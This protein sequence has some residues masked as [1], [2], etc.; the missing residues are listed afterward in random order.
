MNIVV[1]MIKAQADELQSR[2]L[3]LVQDLPDLWQQKHGEKFLLSSLTSSSRHGSGSGSGTG[4]HTSQGVPRTPIH[5]LA[6]ASQQEVIDHATTT[7]ANASTANATSR[8][9]TNNQQHSANS[10]NRPSNSSGNSTSSGMPWSSPSLRA[11][12]TDQL[13][14]AILDGDVQ[15]GINLVQ[16]INKE[17]ETALHVECKRLRSA[18][19]EVID[20]LATM[21]GDK[22][23]LRNKLLPACSPLTLV[24]IRGASTTN[25]GSQLIGQN[26]MGTIGGGG[27]GGGV[28]EDGSY[29]SPL[30]GGM[31][32]TTSSASTTAAVA[33]G[34]STTPQDLERARHSGRKLWIKAAE[35]LIKA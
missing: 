10:H 23:N 15:G 26:A 11:S 14:A 19:I 34:Q 27:A 7:T 8:Y 4:G 29:P 3:D 16:V 30:P 21:M 24:L 9:P 33:A 17:G 12:P 2:F 5:V 25:V 22:I 28:L 13:I 6:T 35:R 31:V 18:S 1:Q 32:A 20:T